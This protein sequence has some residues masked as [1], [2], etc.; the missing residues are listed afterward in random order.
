M[1]SGRNLKGHSGLVRVETVNRR[2]DRSISLDGMK[3]QV[4]QSVA[5]DLLAALSSSLRPYAGYAIFDRIQQ[6]L[7]PVLDRLMS[8]DVTEDG[9]DPGRAEAYTMVL[10]IVRNP[11]DTD[12]PGEKD[13]Q[14]ERY[15]K[16][17][18]ED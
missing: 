14:M 16:R 7:D 12:Y 11:Y 15:N 2:G 13:R 3:F 8:G 10:A 1:N 4:G 17:A 5:E 18:E 6:E 9:R